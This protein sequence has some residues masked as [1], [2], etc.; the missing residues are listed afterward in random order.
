MLIGEGG[1]EVLNYFSFLLVKSLL[2]IVKFGLLEFV[3]TAGCLLS[4]F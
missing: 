3:N 4:T 2:L 1:A